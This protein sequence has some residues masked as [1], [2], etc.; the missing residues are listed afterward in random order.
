MKTTV[1]EGQKRM[2]MII[3]TIML[4]ILMLVS[5]IK[6][7]NSKI[8]DNEEVLVEEQKKADEMRSLIQNIGLE[9][10]YETLKTESQ[11]VFKRNYQ[12]FKANEKIEEIVAQYGVELNSINIGEYRELDTNAYMMNVVQPRDQETYNQM[13]AIMQGSKMQLFLVSEIEISAQV[14]E[15][16]FLQILDAINNISPE[17]PGT[18]DI[19]RF[20]MQ[21][22]TITLDREG[23]AIEANIYMYGMVPPPVDAAEAEE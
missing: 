15:E 19:S 1:T 13:Y 6:P 16:Q 2:I 20:C 3:L 12:S 8:E 9:S 10:E 5:F 18:N 22:P 11:L 23:N 4:C 14:T 7:M 21:I 17:G